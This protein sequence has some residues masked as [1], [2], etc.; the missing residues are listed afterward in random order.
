MIHLYGFILGLAIAIGIHLVTLQA[1][2]QTIN[3]PGLSNLVWVG[4]L[5]GILGARIYHVITDYNLYQHAFWDI[6]KIWQGG[7]S[8]IG[9]IMGGMIAIWSWTKIN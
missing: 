1:K 6:F 8:I 7:L 9:A 5:G 2:R 4:L 3:I